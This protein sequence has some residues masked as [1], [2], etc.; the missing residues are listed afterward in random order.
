MTK[1]AAIIG[2]TG[3]TGQDLVRLIASHPELLL[4]SV[5]A[6]DASVGTPLSV[7]CPS[8]R[9]CCSLVIE[10]TDAGAIGAKAD[11]VFLATPHKLSAELAP[12]LLDAGLTVV[13]ISGGFRFKDA[14]VY[15][16]WYGFKHPSA[17]LLQEAVYGLPELS[18]SDLPGARLIGVGGCYPTAS[19]IPLAPLVAAG[20]VKTGTRPII[21]AISG[22]SGAGRE[23]KEETIFSDVTLR[24]YG[25][26]GHRHLPEIEQAVG[27]DCVFTP[28]VA[29]FDRGIV[30][31]TH[32]EL[33]DGWDTA[34]VR[35]TLEE[36]YADEPFVRLLPD[37]Q[38]PSVASVDRTNDI[39]IASAVDPRGHLV[40]CSAI[41]NLR[42]GASGQAIQCFNVS[43]GLDETMGLVPAPG[44]EVLS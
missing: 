35:A 5:H 38:W 14:S 42:K 8:L 20:A 25:V 29:P 7:R 11:V 41:D 28:H 33:A 16:K 15:E 18:R 36:A 10:P 27:T 6:S 12:S 2:A 43:A 17:G 34:R 22:V 40:L 23:P 26:T 37:G 31:T 44:Q 32:A 4:V 30:A 19:S 9:S 39:E 24:P 1:Q 13:D 21:N 3:Y